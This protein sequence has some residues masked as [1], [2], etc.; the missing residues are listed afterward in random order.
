MTKRAIAYTLCVFILGTLAGINMA[1]AYAM[2]EPIAA[3]MPAYN[4]TYNEGFDAGRK[5]MY[6]ELY[7]AIKNGEVSIIY[8]WY[9]FPVHETQGKA[10][11]HMNKSA[12]CGLCHGV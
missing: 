10:M 12:M 9:V 4:G 2:V 1:G 8:D 7:N 11:L 3:P 6:E 5:D